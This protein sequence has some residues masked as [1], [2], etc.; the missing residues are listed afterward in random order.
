MAVDARVIDDRYELRTL[1]GQGAMGQVWHS[2]D[3]ALRRSVAVKT[4]HP[5]RVTAPSH[6]GQP[7]DVYE[8]FCREAQLVARFTHAGIPVLFDVQLGSGP[9]RPYM[10]MELVLGEDLEQ[11]LH[12]MGRLS[13]PQAVTVAAQLCGIL[14]HTHA[15]PV[16]HRD[17]K[18]GNIMLT[19]DWKVKLLDFGVAAVFGTAY[20]RLTTGRQVLGTLEYMAP[21][22][23]E[24]A[25]AI[26]PRSDL[27]ALACLLYEML[28]GQPPF[29]GDPPAVMY[30]HRHRTPD[31]PTLLRPDIDPALEALILQ[32]LAK[33]PAGRPESA[34]AML[35]RLAPFDTSPAQPTAATCADT[36]AHSV[37]PIPP[38]A[39]DPLPAP[40]RMVQA[41][42]LC[43]EGHFSQALAQ[44]TALAE[45]LVQA[46]PDA[47]EDVVEC[48]A[49]VAY[50]HMQLGNHPVALGAFRGLIEEL[51]TQRT[52]ED[53][54]LLEVRRHHALLL[55]ASGDVRSAVEQLAQLYPVLARLMGKDASATVEVRAALNRI[56]QRG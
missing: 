21:E 7:N 13:I 22:Q 38:H 12:R 44:Y 11:V 1:L 39:D 4:I 55:A 2:W 54:L 14:E 26:S 51:Q 42:A 33:Q 24:E 37:F 30:G 49:K 8:R 17:L 25:P 27:Y 40:V 48:R 31:P 41:L 53:A 56:R 10:V 19:G 5:S 45:E 35:E 6:S 29:T 43:D 20:P 16:I 18:P 34:R 3:R 46:G 15:D 36:V 52:T 32:A 50:C 9:D 28:T 47:R 23:F